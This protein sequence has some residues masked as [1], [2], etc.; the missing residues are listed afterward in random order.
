M[1]CCALPHIPRNGW[2]NY[3][4]VTG[5]LSRLQPT[6]NM[7]LPPMHGD[8][9]DAYAVTQDSEVGFVLG[10]RG[11]LIVYRNRCVNV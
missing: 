9:S 5:N 2:M 8:S 6:P 7:R 1:Y 3:S 10:E 11:L 4:R